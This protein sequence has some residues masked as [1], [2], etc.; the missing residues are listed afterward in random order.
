V[1]GKT[2][3]RRV[4]KLKPKIDRSNRYVQRAWTPA[5]GYLLLLLPPAS[6]LVAFFVCPLVVVMARS[7][8]E[9]TLGFVNFGSILSD[10]VYW[11]V[12]A[13]TFEIAG[14][15]TF[16]TLVLAY[17]VAWVLSLARGSLLHICLAIVIIPFWT[18]V[19]VR[20]FAWMVLF[21]RH[22][23]LNAA[24]LALGT[25]RKPVQL[26]GSFAGLQIGMVHIMLPFMILPLLNAMRSI[27]PAFLRSAA[28]LGANPLRQFWY[29]YL[30]LSAPGVAAGC[31]I[32]FISALGFFVTP[33]LLGSPRDM[34]IAVLIQQEAS[35]LL[36]WPMASALAALLLLATAMLYFLYD[37]I[38]A[39][40]ATSGSP[41]T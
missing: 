21:Q 36:N 27:D 15:V 35:D 3:S 13:N 22:G 1:K 18:S 17:P 38:T 40:F 5:R 6:F 14:T 24:L 4:A 28:L 39:R 16:G 20:T 31:L 37:L 7:V 10:E 30:P 34:M 23:I 41:W 25:A 2:P 11:K 29:I 8:L 32:V 9:P 26:L 19:V 12:F 33:A